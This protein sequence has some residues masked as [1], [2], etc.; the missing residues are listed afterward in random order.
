MHTTKVSNQ[1]PDLYCRYYELF[2]SKVFLDSY[3]GKYESSKK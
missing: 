1:C 3:G 2:F